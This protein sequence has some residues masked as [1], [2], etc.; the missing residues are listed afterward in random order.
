MSRVLII[1]RLPYKNSSSHFSQK[2]R[3][4]SWPVNL[5]TLL[6]VGSTGM[7]IFYY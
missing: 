2:K 4:K 5:R 3:E 1:R 7:I 6:Y